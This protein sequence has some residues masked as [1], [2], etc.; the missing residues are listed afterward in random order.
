MLSR[1]PHVAA[2]YDMD[3]V[4]VVVICVRTVHCALLAY[5]E[6]CLLLNLITC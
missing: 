3:A 5:S 6:F 4:I 2:H 1:L